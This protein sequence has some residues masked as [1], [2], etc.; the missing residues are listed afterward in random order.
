VE[1]GDWEC[2][3][4]TLLLRGS[5]YSEGPDSPGCELDAKL[6]ALLSKEAIDAKYKEIKNGESN[7][8]HV[9]GNRQVWQK[10]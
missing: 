10:I 4:A 7:S 5:K 6:K 1:P 2:K 3:W 8:R 9:A